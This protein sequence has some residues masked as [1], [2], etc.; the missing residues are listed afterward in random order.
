MS[1]AELASA[2]VRLAPDTRVLFM[3]GY[4]DGD[5]LR[6]GLL[7]PGADF[8]PKPFSPEALVRAVR[9]RTATSSASASRSE[10]ADR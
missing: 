10:A 4:T 2:V 6:R 8:L 7:E 5:I 9:V 3:S 1:G